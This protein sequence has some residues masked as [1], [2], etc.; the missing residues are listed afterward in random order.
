[1][2]QITLYVYQTIDGC[3]ARADKRV[4]DAVLKADC[5]LLDEETYLDVFMNHPGWPLTEKET[6]VVAQADCN[7]T[8][9]QPV[10]F[11]TE[12]AV[13]ELSRMKA[14]GDGTMVAYGE[15]IAAV[16]LN[17]GLADEIVVVT[18]PKVA[19]GDEKALQYITGDGA[20]WVVRSCKVLDGEKVR[21]VYGRV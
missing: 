6:F 9:K 1:M 12:D 11:I 3:L 20:A 2:K 21:T 8:E 17:S 15:G 7:L 14:A 13:G 16:L 18:L 4:D 10:K 5:L 19:G